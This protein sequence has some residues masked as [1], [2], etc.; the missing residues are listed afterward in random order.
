MDVLEHRRDRRQQ[1]RGHPLHVLGHLERR[2]PV[3]DHRLVDEQVEEP[4]LRLGDL[5]ARLR[6]DADELEQRDQ[7]EAVAERARH[8]LERGDVLVADPVRQGHRRAEQ[9][10]HPLDQILLDADD[11][12]RLGAGVA[13]RRRRQQVLDGAE[14]EA[15]VADCAADL[16]QGVAALAHPGDDPRLGGRPRGPLAAL[17]LEDPLVR[18]ALQGRRRDPGS[19]RGLA[20]RDRLVGGH[21]CDNLY[22]GR[23]A[24]QTNAEPRLTRFS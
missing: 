11:R 24:A 20:E 10:H 19:A 18:P 4:H 8:P 9:R 23:A 6:V 3:A 1:L 13:P 7:R 22:R 5:A 14:G 12:R 15:A 16:A 17:E 21:L 2:H